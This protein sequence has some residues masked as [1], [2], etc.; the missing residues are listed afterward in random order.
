ME[1]SMSEWIPCSERL[2]EEGAWLV[3]VRV[4]TAQDDS[5]GV[6][7]L[8]YGDGRWDLPQMLPGAVARIVA[9]R[10]LPEPWRG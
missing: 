7:V 5:F 1:E 2:P 8:D 3:T 9:W 10:P 6:L 4:M